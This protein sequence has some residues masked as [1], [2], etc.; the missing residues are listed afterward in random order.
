VR[1][2]VRRR[3]FGIGRTRK[4]AGEEQQRRKPQGEWR[5]D[6]GWDQESRLQ[7]QRQ[8]S[9]GT[10]SEQVRISCGFGAQG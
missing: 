2:G 9:P 6:K 3:G 10:C 5:K 7:G 8:G 1:F 4:K